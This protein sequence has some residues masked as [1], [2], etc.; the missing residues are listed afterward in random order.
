MPQDV[1]LF[2]RSL[3]EIEP[4]FGPATQ[5]PVY[6]QQPVYM[7]QPVPVGQWAGG[8]LSDGRITKGSG[9][10]NV[11]AKDWGCVGCFFFGVGSMTQGPRL[12]WCRH[13]CGPKAPRFGSMTARRKVEVTSSSGCSYTVNFRRTTFLR[14]KL[15]TRSLSQIGN[16]FGERV[17]GCVSECQRLCE[18]DRSRAS[19]IANALESK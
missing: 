13:R 8:T 5:Q 11:P 19:T 9:T 1:V 15:A 4:S 6:G 17:R 12:L 16:A 18:C 2:C 10:A 7:A 14:E 3:A